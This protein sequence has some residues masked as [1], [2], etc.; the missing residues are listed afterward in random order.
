MNQ[1]VLELAK[2]I[3]R[4]CDND[5]DLNSVSDKRYWRG[6]NAALNEVALLAQ[7][8]LSKVKESTQGQT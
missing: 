8:L 7:Q 2:K 4:I 1:E 6:Y 3:A 5:V